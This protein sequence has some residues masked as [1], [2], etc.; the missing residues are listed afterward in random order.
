VT[1]LTHPTL[2]DR[3]RDRRPVLVGAVACTAVGAIVLFAAP[4]AM[5]WVAT[6]ILGLG[7]GGGFS[8]ALVLLA[9]L[10]TSPKAAGGV[11]A[12]TFLVCYSAAAVAPPLVGALHDA[13]GGYG[14]PFAVLACLGCVEL[15]IATRFRPNLRGA[16]A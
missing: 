8:L 6:A 1:A 14:P 4:N 10:S 15:A 13:V 7:L 5:P 2:V 3:M 9:D 16:V 11:A 12:M